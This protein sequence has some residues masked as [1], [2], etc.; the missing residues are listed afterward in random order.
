M[1]SAART[2]AYRAS[3]RGVTVR[4]VTQRFNAPPGW[5]VPPDFVPSADWQPDPSWPPA[6]AGWSF[7]VD[8]AA[9]ANDTS[10]SVDPTNPASQ[11]GAAYGAVPP[12]P[13]PQGTPYGTPPAGAFGSTAPGSAQAVVAEGQL[14]SAKKSL[15]I[16]L[17][18]IVLVV[19][20]VFATERLFWYLGIIGIILAIK[21]LVDMNKAKKAIA[22]SQGPYGVGGTVPG[23]TPPGQNPPG[24]F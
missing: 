6:P 18:L 15:W 24:T 3:E 17:G 10:L 11:P 22:A 19:V 1:G 12:G 2:A 16:G 7:W 20:L 4:G 23:I 14:S 8:D 9:P 13:A 5:N 21:G